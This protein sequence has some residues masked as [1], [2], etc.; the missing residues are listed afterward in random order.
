MWCSL[1][2]QELKEYQFTSSLL[3]K[4][5]AALFGRHD[6]YRLKITKHL[7]QNYRNDCLLSYNSKIGTWNPRLESY[8]ADDKEWYEEH[9]PITLD[10]QGNEGW[11][12]YQKSLEHI[13]KHIDLYF[14]EIVC[15]TDTH[16]N[17]FFTEKTLKNFYLQKPFI[18]MAGHHSLLE[19]KDRGFATFAPWIDETYDTISCPNKRLQAI[20]LEIDRIAKMPMDDIN[21]MHQDLMPVFEHNKQNFLKICLTC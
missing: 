2:Y 15:E 18:L 1:I 19:L 13:K 17:K 6:L 9:C 12:P 14:I 21:K 7:Y 11:V 4:K 20:L 5:F 10:F 8:F 16:S 3:S